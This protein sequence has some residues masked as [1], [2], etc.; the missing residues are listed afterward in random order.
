[1]SQKPDKSDKKIGQIGQKSDKTPPIR[2]RYLNRSKECKAA[3][4]PQFPR[5]DQRLSTQCSSATSGVKR[6]KN[7]KK[8]PFVCQMSGKP[9]ISTIKGGL[10]A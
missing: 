9:S 6:R 4:F 1:V 10:V 2:N 8:T 3:I 7:P 5:L